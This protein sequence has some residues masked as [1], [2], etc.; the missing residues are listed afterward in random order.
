MPDI[1]EGPND[2]LA[3]A[4]RLTARLNWLPCGRRAAPVRRHAS[5]AGPTTG[6]LTWALA[7]A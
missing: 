2:E 3:F 4:L 1:D 5:V 7:Q 6:A